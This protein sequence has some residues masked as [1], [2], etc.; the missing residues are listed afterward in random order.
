MKDSHPS[1][2]LA[3]FLF[4]FHLVPAFSPAQY[5][6][7]SWESFEL[8]G[9]PPGLI[10]GH[11]ADQETVLP[12]SYTSPDVPPGMSSGI[13]LLECGSTGLL[14][15]PNPKKL[16][17]SLVS[18]VSLDRR[19]LG[20]TGKALYQADVYLPAKGEPFPNTALLAT[21]LEP[22]AT[23]AGGYKMYRFGFSEKGER[24]FFAYANTDINA[25][26]GAPVVYHQQSLESFNLKRPGWH[27]LQM[28]F[29][30]Q[31]QIYCAIDLQVT[32]FSP[33]KENSLSVLNSGIMVASSA[34]NNSVVI[35]NLSIQWT[36][37]N[38]PLPDSPWLLPVA[39]GEMPNVSLMESG[40]TVFWLTDAQKAWNLS[41]VQK[42]PILVQ[43]F[44]PRASTYDHLKKM[45]PN[46]AETRDLLNRFVLLKVDVNQLAG[47]TLAERFS[48]LRVPTLLVMG[49]D[50]RELKRVTYAG[51]QTTWDQIRGELLASLA[52]QGLTTAQ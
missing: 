11:A 1:R 45:T 37:E 40:S 28:I 29:D 25:T 13:A 9:I 48:I 33:V 47:G 21:V 5:R 32:K 52:P 14:F 26:P 20:T 27:R 41:T 31:D 39:D 15:K 34:G 7:H 43:F 49:S 8:G 23:R 44:A 4:L 30:G 24:V 50:G 3:I 36:A 42:R 18:P 35:D 2:F 12:Y 22:G 19:L 17:L 16:H 10:P 51:T 6:V 46:D 38:V